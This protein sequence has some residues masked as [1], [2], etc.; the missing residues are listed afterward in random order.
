[1]ILLLYIVK[2]IQISGY[3]T[4]YV[5]VC[6]EIIFKNEFINKKKET[7]QRINYKCI[8]YIYRNKNKGNLK[9]KNIEFVLI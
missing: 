1:M 6:K 4:I 7:K 3:I 8:L 9:K 5:Y 2:I